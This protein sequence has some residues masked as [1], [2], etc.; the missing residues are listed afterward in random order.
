[1]V[2]TLGAFCMTTRKLPRIKYIIR[3][4]E[5]GESHVILAVQWDADAR[6]LTLG[7]PLGVAHIRQ[8]VA[9]ERWR[10]TDFIKAGSRWRAHYRYTCRVRSQLRETQAFHRLM[11][12]LGREWHVQRVRSFR[13]LMR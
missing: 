7:G 9:G 12:R 10:E 1:L 3:D 2:G 11:V 4:G 6:R 13:R 5:P 8:D